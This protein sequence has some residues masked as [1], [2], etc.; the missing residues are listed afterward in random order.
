MQESRPPTPESKHLPYCDLVMKGGITSGIVYPRAVSW[1]ARRH[2]FRNIGGASAG[3][4][5]AAMAA[6]AE[7]GREGGGFERLDEVAADAGGRLL[8]LFQPEPATEPLFRAGLAT[9]T[10]GGPV[11]RVSRVLD[12][13][14]RGYPLA[15][16]AGLV[17]GLLALAWAIAG[18]ASVLG[19]LAV[20]LL[21]AL[22]LATAL[23]L[24]V[25]QAI[26][27]EIPQQGYGLCSGLR[28]APER[29]GAEPA[30]TEWLADQLD[31]VAGRMQLE[32]EAPERPLTFGDLRGPNDDAAI[33]LEVMTTCLTARRPYRIPFQHDDLMFR[34][35]E[36]RRLFPARVME[37]IEEKSRPYDT[38]PG[39][40]YLPPTEN[41][42][43]V[44]A[45]RMSLSFPLLISAVP[46]HARDFNLLDEAA[47]ERPRPLWF[48]DGGIS[49]NFPIHF[50]DSIWPRW[51]TFGITLE[52]FSPEHH[53]EGRDEVWMPGRAIE[54]QRFDF[55]PMGGVLSFLAAIRS[56]MQDWQDNMQ[57]VLPGYRERIVHVRLKDYE[58]G[59]NL[60][61]EEETVSRLMDYG[62]LAG[63]RIDEDFDFESHR[64]RRFLV[65][66]ARFEETLAEL[67]RTYES[68]APGGETLADFLQRYPEQ[69]RE[70]RQ[71]LK[72]TEAAL[73][74]VG[75]LME[76]ARVWGE[77]PSLREGRIP[78][79]GTDL[80][81]TARS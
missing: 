39:F 43:V 41:L 16:L 34:V 20:V 2:R 22:G 1:L 78:K 46:L 68:A 13:L 23:V 21:F 31:Y 50:F 70:Y 64:W 18:G 11:A 79:P 27:R 5:A 14:M 45:V 48:S 7:H 10:G 81:V 71:T 26:V 29:A 58:G 72:W 24:R 51:P 38:D 77:E 65:S 4:I 9:M 54:G 47:R 66:V 57:S 55:F 80:R 53:Q 30:L 56:S 62:K 75:E 36:W 63:Q 15:S 3:A 76:T 19:W 42:P 37:W 25:R 44:V 35:E 17:P 61:M 49:S 59:L 28:S 40:R 60:G 33:N 52:P 6:A 73:R 32:G 12:A 74:D 67:L 69:A 8:S